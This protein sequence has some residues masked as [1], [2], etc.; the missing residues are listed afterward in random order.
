MLLRICRKWRQQTA[1]ALSQY[2]EIAV[3]V[4]REIGI[5]SQIKISFTGQNSC[6][7]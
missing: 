1:G 6:A 2:F 7:V 3:D 4:C 5:E